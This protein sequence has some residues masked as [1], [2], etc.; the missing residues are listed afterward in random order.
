[1]VQYPAKELL[2]RVKLKNTQLER[3]EYT[4]ELR[5]VVEHVSGDSRL[6]MA[7]AP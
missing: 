4:Q 7:I 2:P 1:M 5:L 6:S 3:F